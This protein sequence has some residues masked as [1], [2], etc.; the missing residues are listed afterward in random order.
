[1]SKKLPI[2]ILG[3]GNIGTDLL[4][5]VLRSH[6]L[7]CVLFA[8]RNLSSHGMAKASHLGVPVSAT[9]I[10]GIIEKANEI[11]IVFDATNAVDHIQHASIL[12]TFDIKIVDLTPSKI[13]RMCL[14]AVN[15]DECLEEQNVNM[16]TCGGQS[17]IPLAHAIAEANPGLEYVETVST[18][19]SRSA[20]PATRLNLDEYLLTT[21]S[22]LK[23]FTSCPDSKAILNLNPAKP[24]VHM[25]TTVMAKIL[26]PD[27]SKTRVK[28]NETV[29]QISAYVPGYRLVL[30]P[31]LEDNRLITMVRVDGLGDHLPKYAGNL[32]IINCAAIF[33]AE[34]FVTKSRMCNA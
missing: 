6:F 31:F 11:A 20:G 5:K 18:I 2:A 10:K 27:I 21:E 23:F 16:V 32:D 12:K 34:A 13:G 15:L 17:S 25:Q 9:G 30:E 4:V 22:A 26:K 33:F 7:E 8:G 1:M 24:C 19:A 29:K 3:T 14:P 28:I